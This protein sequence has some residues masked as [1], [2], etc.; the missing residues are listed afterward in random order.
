M[1]VAVTGGIGCGKTTVLSEFSKLGVPCFLADEVAGSYYSESDFLSKIRILFG[2]K[3]INEDGSANKRAIADIVFNDAHAMEQLNS[4]VHPRVIAD[5]HSFSN[6]HADAPYVIFESAI[7]YEYGF[8]KL[9]DKVIC[10]YLEKEE[11]LRRLEIRDRASRQQLEDRIRNQMSAEEKMMR[12]DHVI[13][14]YEGNPRT[15]QVMQIHQ[16]LMAVSNV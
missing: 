11:R 9:M 10:V 7:L 8:E 16:Q 13:L 14:N 6:S 1:I 4:L 2:D 15:R 5:F 12:A 3:V